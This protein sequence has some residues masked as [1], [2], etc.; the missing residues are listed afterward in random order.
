MVGILNVLKPTEMTSFDVVAVVRRV[1]KTKKV[2][3][4]GTLDP[5]AVGVLPICVGKATK[6]VEKLT[7]DQK[8]YRCEMTL[9]SSTDTQDSTGSTIK[10]S[11]DR[12]D[13][14]EIRSVIESFVGE[15]YQIPPM[16]SALK[17]DG[18]KL[19]DLAREGITVK[20]QPRKRHIYSIDIINVT[21][22]TVLCDVTCS[23]GT[24]IRT[25]CDDIGEK[26][27]CFAHMSLLIRT[28][29]GV[30][31]INST[32]SIEELLELDL[33]DIKKRMYEI[34][35]PFTSYPSIS[36]NEWSYKKIK[37]GVK[38]DLSRNVKKNASEIK[39]SKFRVYYAD[40]FLGIAEYSEEKE[41]LII[42]KLLYSGDIYESGK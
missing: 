29:S 37:D 33:N 10:T 4:T 30:F 18:R 15:I 39:T 11:K 1:L 32:I 9:G 14:S 41:R 21:T 40:I 25:L 23:K 22:D 27:G 36:V 38:I 5:M 3:H 26:L 8:T 34:D 19:C 13:E 17:V 6:V 42:T 28:K 31:D 7:E 20:R 12:P 35:Y 2:G 24:Y 16:Y